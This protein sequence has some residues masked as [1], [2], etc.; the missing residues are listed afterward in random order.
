MQA[1]Y[2]QLGY[3]HVHVRVCIYGAYIYRNTLQAWLVEPSKEQSEPLESLASIIRMTSSR[4][5]APT[6]YHVTILIAAKNGAVTT[7]TASMTTARAPGK[8]V[9][10]DQITPYATD[11]TFCLRLSHALIF[12]LNILQSSYIA[13][14]FLRAVFSIFAL[15][16]IFQTSEQS[17]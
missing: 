2:E 17:C 15:Q 13:I 1:N 16:T 12:F 5:L 10:A 8:F 11:Q 9:N 4:L 14:I 7:T 6:A 3:M